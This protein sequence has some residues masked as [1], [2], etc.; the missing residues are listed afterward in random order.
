[1]TK[2]HV[3]DRWEDQHG[4]VWISEYRKRKDRVRKAKARRRLKKLGAGNG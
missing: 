4:G 1:M 3:G 2:F